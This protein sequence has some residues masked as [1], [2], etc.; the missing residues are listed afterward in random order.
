STRDQLDGTIARYF[1]GVSDLIVL[2][3]GAD[4]VSA[5]LRWET[6]RGGALFPHLYGVLALD[7]V[8]RTISI[9]L[10]DA[11]ARFTPSQLL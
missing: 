7:A 9:P 11:C 2:E 6:S 4:R 1:A 8:V 3:I 5:A 10:R